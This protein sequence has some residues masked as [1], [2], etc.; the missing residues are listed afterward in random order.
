[1]DLLQL[2]CV[3]KNHSFTSEMKSLIQLRIL[4]ALV[5]NYKQERFICENN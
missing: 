1:M 3:E 5:E 4:T 2:L